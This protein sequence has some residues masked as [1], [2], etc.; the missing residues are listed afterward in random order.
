MSYHADAEGG[1]ALA[2]ERLG[3]EEQT[4]EAEVLGG[5]EALPAR[6]RVSGARHAPEMR[7]GIGESAES[8]GFL[9]QAPVILEIVRIDG[10]GRRPPLREPLTCRDGQ[11]RVPTTLQPF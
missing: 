3:Q 1:V 6:R 5:I 10:E 11:H 8:S 2:A 4:V 9:Q 7:D